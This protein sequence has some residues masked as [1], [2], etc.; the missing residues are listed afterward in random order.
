MMLTCV[1]LGWGRRDLHHRPAVCISPERRGGRDSDLHQRPRRQKRRGLLREG[2]LPVKWWPEG[3]ARPSCRSTG[4]DSRALAP[5]PLVPCLGP[6][7]P[8]ALL[9]P[10]VSVAEGGG[11]A[12]LLT[13]LTLAPAMRRAPRASS[14]RARRREAR[15]S[16]LSAVLGRSSLFMM[17]ICFS[18]KCIL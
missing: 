3:P 2:H 18:A 9:G 12:V 4:T 7:S 14:A 15:G 8:R 11:D 13:A 17:L 16:C 5:P 1:R 10:L 6:S